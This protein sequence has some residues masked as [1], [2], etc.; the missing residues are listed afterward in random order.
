MQRLGVLVLA[1]SALLAYQQEIRFGNAV[2]R[3]PAGW[4]AMDHRGGVLAR[5]GALRP[6]QE[7]MI[8]FLPSRPLVGDFQAQ[9]EGLVHSVIPREEPGNRGAL[10]RLQRDGV[11]ILSQVIAL[12]AGLE[13]QLWIFVAMTPGGRFESY[14]VAAAPAALHQ[15]YQRELQELLGSLTYQPGTPEGS[16]GQQ[17]APTPG[18]TTGHA[19]SAYQGQAAGAHDGAAPRQGGF[20]GLPAL[21]P[22]PGWAIGRAVDAN[23]GPLEN[24]TVT[25]VRTYV[26]PGLAT[27][28]ASSTGV[29]TG[30]NGYYETPLEGGVYRITAYAETNFEGRSFRTELQPLDGQDTRNVCPSRD[31]IVKDFVLRS[32]G[33]QAGR[34]Q[35]RYGTTNIGGSL[36]IQDWYGRPNMYAEVILTPLGPLMDGSPGQVIRQAG[37]VVFYMADIPLGRYRVEVRVGGRMMDFEIRDQDNTPHGRGPLVFMPNDAGIPGVKRM[38]LMIR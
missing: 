4:R 33:V 15:Q 7:Y 36:S 5:P 10:E 9:F 17:Q 25:I 29:L 35:D 37:Q 11:E 30:R 19:R 20:P 31:G 18:A 16:W 27:R 22:R 26:D 2:F 21:Q 6:G 14:V 13:R 38:R 12:G 24:F 34:T 8:H 23:G 28:G 3:L 32:T 1:A